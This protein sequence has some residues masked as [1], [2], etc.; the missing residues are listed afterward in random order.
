VLDG[1][2]EG[3]CENEFGQD[4]EARPGEVFSTREHAFLL[5]A[6]LEGGAFRV[7]EVE[8]GTEPPTA[9]LSR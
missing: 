1:E 6:E 3:E 5:E 4:E 7:N 8:R 9:R 2:D